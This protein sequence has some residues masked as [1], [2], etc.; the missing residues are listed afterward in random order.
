[1]G[2]KLLREPAAVPDK[3]HDQTLAV[4]PGVEVGVEDAW[5]MAEPTARPDRGSF[6]ASRRCT[7]TCCS[8]LTIGFALMH[9]VRVRATPF[10]SK[11]CGFSRYGAACEYS[12]VLWGG[13]PS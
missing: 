5:Q 7:M 10:G 1:M 9:A 13:A 8:A 4:L 6:V 3:N 12:R 2:Q 11:S